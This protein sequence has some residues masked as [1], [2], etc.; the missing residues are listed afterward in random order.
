MWDEWDLWDGERDDKLEFDV[1][2][3]GF[4]VLY[5]G[6][7]R[8]D[9]IKLVLKVIDMDEDGFVDWNEF[10]LYLKWVIC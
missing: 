5:F 2:Y 6:C 1:F 7:Y 10:S 4:L 8:C 3:N 9:E